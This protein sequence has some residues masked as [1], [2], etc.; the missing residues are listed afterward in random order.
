[1][2]KGGTTSL[3]KWGTKSLAGTESLAG[4]KNP[5]MKNSGTKNP[6][7]PHDF[8][9]CLSLEVCIGGSMALNI[10]VEYT[11]QDTQSCY[12][13]KDTSKTTQPRPLDNQCY[14]EAQRIQFEAQQC[15][16]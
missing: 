2:K 4:T 14:L 11:E 3:E 13:D 10:L 1:M 15:Q 7:S 5:G 8:A 9:L 16:E 6:G 12:M